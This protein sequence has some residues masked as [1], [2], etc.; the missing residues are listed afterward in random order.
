MFWIILGLLA[1]LVLHLESK[2]ADYRQ[3]KI[4]E[5]WDWNNETNSWEP[6]EDNK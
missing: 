3:Q 6:K 5:T 4:K 2:E 1:F